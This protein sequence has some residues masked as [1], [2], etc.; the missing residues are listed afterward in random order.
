MTGVAV[1]VS[2]GFGRSVGRYS[3]RP[4]ALTHCRSKQDSNRRSRRW[5]IRALTHDVVFLPQS[6]SPSPQ[7]EFD[8][9]GSGASGTDG[10]RT[11]PW[12]GTEFEPSVPRC[13]CTADSAGGGVTPPDPGGEWRLPGPPPDRSIDAPRPATARMTGAPVDRPQLGRTQRNRCLPSAELNVRI[14]S[15]PAVSQQ[16]FGSSQDDARCSSA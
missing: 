5:K 8:T 12:R 7:S 13:A 16:T 2:P 9:P 6:H 10:S 1:G 11:L 4:L 14:H 3:R 15:P